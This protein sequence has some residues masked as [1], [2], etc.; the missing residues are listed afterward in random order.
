ME[1][2][3]LGLR[4]LS[5]ASRIL[6]L[7]TRMRRRTRRLGAWMRGPRRRRWLTT[8]L[9]LDQRFVSHYHLP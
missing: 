8:E 3:D 9:V 5:F 6:H 4:L 1:T 7:T 2:R